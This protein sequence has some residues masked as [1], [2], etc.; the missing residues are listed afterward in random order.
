MIRRPPRSTLLPYTTLFRSSGN[1]LLDG[2]T[3]AD[4]MAGGAGNDTYM[5]ENAS[6]HV[7]NNAAVGIHTISSSWNNITPANV[8]NL[9][10]TGNNNINATGN[11]LGIGITGNSG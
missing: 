10:V 5:V 7:I 3:G 6:E 9:T 4:T 11:E 8:D 2:G 1:N